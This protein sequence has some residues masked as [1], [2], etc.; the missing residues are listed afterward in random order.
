MVFDLSANEKQ[1]IDS[2]TI[3]D[4]SWIYANI[5]VDDTVDVNGSRKLKVMM[6]FSR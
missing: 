4:A 6:I 1:L 5:L 2:A 3:L